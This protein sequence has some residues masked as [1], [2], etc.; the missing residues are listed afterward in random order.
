M[1]VTAPTMVNCPGAIPEET[2]PARPMTH[3]EIAADLEAR[4][5]G[6]EYPPGSFIPSLSQFRDLYGVS[7]STAEKVVALLRQAGLIERWPGRGN[8]VV[9]PI[10]PAADPPNG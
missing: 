7:E 4:I 2:V 9:E 1:D 8:A 5:R 3:P 6:G 10:P